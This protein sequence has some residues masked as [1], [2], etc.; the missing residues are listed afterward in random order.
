MAAAERGRAGARSPLAQSQAFRDLANSTGVREAV[1]PILGHDAFITRSLLF[2]KRQGA[3]WDVTWHRDTTIAVREKHETSGYGPWSIKA[4]VHHVRPPV[5]VLSSMLTIRL[6][7]DDCDES[8]GALLVVPG[9]HMEV[10]LDLMQQIDANAAR[11]NEIVCPVPAGG[12]L[13]MRPLILHASKKATDPTRRRRVLHLEFA[14][15]ALDG[16]LQWAVD[17]RC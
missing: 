15:E 11:S 5:R 4:D 1:E 3:N 17:G 9:S 7:L 2:D 14:A 6:H 12:A 16:D 10:N 8:N 13:L